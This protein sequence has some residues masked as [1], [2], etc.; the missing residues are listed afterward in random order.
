MWRIEESKVM[1]RER[2]KPAD[3]ENAVSRQPEAE[4]GSSST[5]GTEMT[6]ADLCGR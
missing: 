3:C 4:L 6:H 2:P 1:Q 5:A